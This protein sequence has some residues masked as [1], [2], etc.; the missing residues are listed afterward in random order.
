MSDL[1]LNKVNNK[2]YQEKITE[3]LSNFPIRKNSNHN[4]IKN[5][6]NTIKLRNK[7]S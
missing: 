4:G 1:S 6:N 7:I 2:N 5:I 3:Y